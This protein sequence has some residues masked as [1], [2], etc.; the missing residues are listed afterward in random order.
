MAYILAIEYIDHIDHFGPFPTKDR[1]RRYLLVGRRQ[2]TDNDEFRTFTIE[3]L[4]VPYTV[5]RKIDW[6]SDQE[7][8]SADGQ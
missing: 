4:I 1:A 6:R 2:L 8:A 5:V 3:P 7:A